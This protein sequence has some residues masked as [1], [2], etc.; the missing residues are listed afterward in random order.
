MTKTIKRHKC[1]PKKISSQPKYP[2]SNNIKHNTVEMREE[3]VSL[4]PEVAAGPR[5]TADKK[6]IEAVARDLL[7]NAQ[8]DDM[9]TLEEYLVLLPVEPRTVHRWAQKNEALRKAIDKTN[10][11]IG[12]RREK[13]MIRKEFEPQR[14]A[15]CMHLYLERYKD[16]DAYHDKRK[17]QQTDNTIKAMAAYGLPTIPSSPL[18]PEKPKDEEDDG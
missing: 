8:K 10:T 3:K 2:T 11:L 15:Y 1:P 9:L 12:I 18:V 5:R 17:Q 14:T 6:F 7:R 13:G 16:A 4:S